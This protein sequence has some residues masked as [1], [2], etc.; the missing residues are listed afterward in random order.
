V[1]IKIN[2]R[3]QFYT[4]LGIFF[5][6][7]CVIG[8]DLTG[9][10]PQLESLVFPNISIGMLFLGYALINAYARLKNTNT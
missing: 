3:R 2:E 5:L 9:F 10:I 4:A 8:T 7:S 1:G 6:L